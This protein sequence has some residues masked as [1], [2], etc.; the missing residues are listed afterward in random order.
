LGKK[1]GIDFENV[2]VEGYRNINELYK[3]H[4]QLHACETFLE[5]GMPKL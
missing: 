3:Q 2:K 5:I 4:T 1:L